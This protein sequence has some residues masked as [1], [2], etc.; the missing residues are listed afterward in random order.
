VGA[1][2]ET[3]AGSLRRRA[4]GAGLIRA[5]LVAGT[6]GNIASLYWGPAALDVADSRDGAASRPGAR[7]RDH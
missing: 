1:V 6:V 7:D 5:G 4:F 2:L 3:L